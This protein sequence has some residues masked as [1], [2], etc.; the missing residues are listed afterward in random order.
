MD[1]TGAVVCP[2]TFVVN[3]T[4]SSGNREMETILTNDE[5]AQFTVANIFGEWAP[6]QIAA[7][8]SLTFAAY[9]NTIITS[10]S[11]GNII[12]GGNASAYLVS[13]DNVQTIVTGNRLEVEGGVQDANHITVRAANGRGGFGPATIAEIALS[14]N[15]VEESS[16]VQ[17]LIENGQVVIL[18]DGVKYNT[19]GTVIR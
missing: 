5:A 19:L 16:T 8:D 6:D 13:Y 12:W 4:H 9:E 17:K 2:S 18:R 10:S 1:S 3:F 7:Q 14:L 11:H 15:N